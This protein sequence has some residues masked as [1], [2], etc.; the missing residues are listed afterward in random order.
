METVTKH[1]FLVALAIWVG[2]R[3][4]VANKAGVSLKK[5]IFNP[6]KSAADL[7]SITPEEGMALAAQE[8]GRAAFVAGSLASP[9]IVDALRAQG[10]AV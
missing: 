10:I 8:A 1:P 6:L 5:A 2:Y 7:T 3:W 9:A 4:S